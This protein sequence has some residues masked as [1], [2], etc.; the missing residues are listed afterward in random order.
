MD[1]KG[2]ESFVA[3]LSLDSGKEV[4][5]YS[6]PALQKS[7]LG[8]ISRLP[9]SIRVVLES[10]LRN[11]DNTSITMDD[12]KALLEW[13][14]KNPSDRD[15]PFKVSRILM[16]DFTGVPAV[17][18]LA[19]MRQFVVDKG[20]TP[21]T[22]QPTINVDLIIDHSVQVDSFNTIQSMAINQEKE[23]ELGEIQIP[24]MVQ[25]GLQGFQGLSAFCGYMPPGESRIPGNMRHA[26]AV[27]W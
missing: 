17:V 6:L 8:S 9:F 19:A 20:M 26:Q 18:D 1:G 16:Q 15:V 23:I 3:K 22:I 13:D 14:A 2:N 12:V 4:E 11:V 25:L 5:Y 7:G 27:R 21:E 10:L 24:E